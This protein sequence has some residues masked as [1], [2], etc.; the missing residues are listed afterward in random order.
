VGD[1][2]RVKG[3]SIYRLSQ[4]HA[5]GCGVCIRLADV[6]EVE[7][8]DFSKIKLVQSGVEAYN[9]LGIGERYHDPLRRVFHKVEKHFPITSS[10]LELALRLAV[11]AMN[12]K[13]DPNGLVPSFLVFGVVLRFPIIDANVSDYEQRGLAMKVSREEHQNVVAE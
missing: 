12:Y 11:K 3:D 6:E 7:F 9:F 1:V 2:L 5:D 10:S 8:T 4:G 13:M